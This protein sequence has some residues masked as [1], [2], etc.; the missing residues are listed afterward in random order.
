MICSLRITVARL[1]FRKAVE[2]IDYAL[3]PNNT[4]YVEGQTSTGESAA[5]ESNNRI[6][7][8]AK[9]RIND[10]LGLGIEMSEGD[11]G[12]ALLG[13]V[14]YRVSDDL[15]L[16]IGGGFG[17]G[18]YGTAGATINLD[19]GYQLYGSYGIDPDST[20]DRQRNVTTIGQR[21]VLGNGAK[22]F[23]EHQWTKSDSEDGV[24]NVFGIEYAL[25]DWASI[26]ATV[27]RGEIE[28]A[29]IEANRD[30]ASI[31]ASIQRDN[32][33]LGSRLEWRRDEGA[34]N[35]F[36]QWLTSTSLEWKQSESTRW[37]AK[38]NYSRTEDNLTGDDAARLAEASIGFAYRP[39]WTDRFNVLGRY[40]YLDDLVA[41]QQLLNRPD[42]RS[43]VAALESLYK[44][45]K[46][47][48]IHI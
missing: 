37:L 4:P 35:Q 34:V 19:N 36:E 44:L 24:T 20:I 33:R 42:Q 15:A 38:L 21:L 30:A 43:H 8:G 27:Q 17:D 16:D 48:L 31:G 26:S 3:N 23:N 32:L 7:V 47:S 9:R 12:A 1:H 18:A 2:R 5:F 14:E 10:R 29:G 13:S 39:V 28:F 41:P 45:N 40:T 6:A 46:L 25:N 22:I 11:R